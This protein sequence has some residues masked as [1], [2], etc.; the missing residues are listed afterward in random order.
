MQSIP[1]GAV[2][3][4]KDGTLL[5]FHATW[6]PTF[7]AVFRE[8]LDDDEALLARV[9]DTLAL[10][11]QTG[12]V[13]Q[14]SPLVAESTGELAARVAPL[15]GQTDIASLATTLDALARRR[16]AQFVTGIPGARGVVDRIVSM[17]LPVP[18][19]TNDSELTARD[20]L[21]SLGLLDAFQMVLGY[22]SGHGTKPH[23]GMLAHT[24]ARLGVP[25]KLLVMVGDTPTDIQ[26]AV[27][28][29]CPSVL[30][31]PDRCHDCA[32]DVVVDSLEDVPEAIHAAV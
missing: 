11:L 8:L 2:A 17:G 28:A 10:D 3:F 22:D 24:S 18:L 31:D 9:A 4:D 21:E 12:R 15:V 29:G 5:D 23:P 27:A 14:D 30:I 16:S 1:A 19:A 6:G 32:A 25:S 7:V 26:A 13:G 20:Q